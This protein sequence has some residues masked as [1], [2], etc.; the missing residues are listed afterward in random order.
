VECIDD[1]VIDLFSGITDYLSRNTNIGV[2]LVTFGNLLIDGQLILILVYWFIKLNNFR[3]PFG[4]TVL[5]IIK[6]LIGVLICYI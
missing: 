3:L 4:I 5:G 2:A 1:A 6:M